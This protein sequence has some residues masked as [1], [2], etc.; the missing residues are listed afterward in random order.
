MTRVVLFGGSGFIGSHVRNHLRGVECVA[1]SRT[2]VDLLSQSDTQAVL[3][4]GDVV[5]N[6]AGYPEATDRTPEGLARLRAA[7]VDSVENLARAAA[8]IGVDRVIH[9]SSV[10]AMGRVSGVGRREEDSGP[11]ASPYAQ[12]KKDA[13][14]VLESARG[15]PTTI[16][17][18][19]S[20]FGEGRS[21]ARMLS[22]IARLPVLPLP[23][24]GE[25]LVPFTYV[26]NV[27]DAIVLAATQTEPLEGTYI[28]G[29]EHSYRL[30]EVILELAHHMGA[31]PRI[32]PAPVF[33]FRWLARGQ[34]LIDRG[35]RPLIDDG[36]MNT[37]TVSVSY[38]IERFQSASGYVPRYSLSE[39][40]ARIARWHQR[41]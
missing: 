23:G 31:H 25:T 32:F 2:E 3:R 29:D 11:I 5:I 21:L 16:L 35:R 40:T 19:T 22:R 15:F 9:I 1:P 30:R 37:L 33:A 36:R 12:S 14:V 10:A 18:P 39:A 26:G 7:N 38:S 34:R 6:A 17:R 27:A 41:P 13:E 28:I 20:V 4:R 24:G 8:A